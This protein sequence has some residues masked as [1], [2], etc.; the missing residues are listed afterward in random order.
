M[1]CIKETT[2]TL[3]KKLLTNHKGLRDNDNKL[4]A[5]IWYLKAD[6]IEEGA[7]SFLDQIAEGKLP[8][9]E[10]IRRCRQKLQELNPEL[11]GKLWNKRHGF[12]KQ[13]KKELKEME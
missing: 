1:K 9:S 7:L 2:Q 10:S 6:K 8:S 4:L 5:T 12:Q 3:I 13:I 11:R